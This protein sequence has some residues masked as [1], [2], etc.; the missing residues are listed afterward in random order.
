MVSWSQT[1]FG[2]EEV[3]LSIIKT[4]HRLYPSLISTTTEH[5]PECA[6]CKVPYAVKH[7][8]TDCND[9]APIHQRF[10]GIQHVRWQGHI[11]RRSDDHPTRVIYQFDPPSANWLQRPPYRPRSWKAV[12][13]RFI[14]RWRML[15]RSAKTMRAGGTRLLSR[16]Q[17]HEIEQQQKQ[18][19]RGAFQEDKRRDYRN[20]IV[21]WSHH[22]QNC[23]YLRP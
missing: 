16:T 15:R 6:T 13:S 1:F 7:I 9:L 17:W 12:V 4:G 18:K 14:W 8:L 3:I 20:L 19:S 2:K 10:Y 23:F 22:H 21:G 5:A 11:L